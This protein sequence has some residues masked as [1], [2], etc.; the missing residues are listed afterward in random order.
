M[1]EV[2]SFSNWKGGSGK[3]TSCLGVYS[4]LAGE[5]GKKVLLVDVDAQGNS[6]KTMRAKEN[7]KHSLSLMMRSNSIEEVIQETENGFIIPATSALTTAES[8]V[9]PI[10]KES[11]LKEAIDSIRDEWDYIL[12]DCPPSMDVCTLAALT[13]SDKVVVP[14][15]AE[16][17]SL[18]G[19]DGLFKIF[20]KIKT[21]YNPK[22]NIDGI[23]LNQY[24]DKKVSYKSL[25]KA[26][27]DLASDIGSR[28][29][30]THIRQNITIAEAQ[31]MRMLL[32]Q[33]DEKKKSNGY[34]DFKNLVD[35]LEGSR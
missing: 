10:G 4:I 5:Y 9:D 32:H 27:S 34:E 31:L 3:T 33:Y 22:L 13:A 14:V 29:Y 19:L 35:E 28:V 23:L 2:I 6:S 20:I 16:I 12:I 1:A 7:G 15:R 8:S 11:C 21:Y 25:Y 30:D 18:D 17:F 24:D 26:F